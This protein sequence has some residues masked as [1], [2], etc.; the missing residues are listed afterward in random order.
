M[1]TPMVTFLLSPTAAEALSV[2]DYADVVR[3]GNKYRVTCSIDAATALLAD[4]ELRADPK[5]SGPNGWDQPPS[6]RRAAKNAAT[7]IRGALQRP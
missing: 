6:W 4:A 1:K 5:M 2:D 3:V 7:Q